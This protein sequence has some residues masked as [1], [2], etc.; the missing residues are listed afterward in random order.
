MAK[1]DKQKPERP[2]EGGNMTPVSR[3]GDQVFREAGPWTPTIQRLLAHLRE[4]GLEWVPE[5]QGWTKDGRE[6]LAYL[7]GKVPTY[8]L[9]DWVY[10]EGVRAWG[11]W[12]WRGQGW[13]LVDVSE[14]DPHAPPAPLTA[15][16]ARPAPSR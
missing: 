1:P 15:L 7:K 8:P 14:S 9:P 6:A 4:Q 2:L 5:P 16:T 12:E 10:D 3:L 13:V 11:L